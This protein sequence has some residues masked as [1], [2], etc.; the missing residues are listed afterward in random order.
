MCVA[1]AHLMFFLI[2]V[3]DAFRR[4]FG[5]NGNSPRHSKGSLYPPESVSWTFFKNMH[6]L[7]YKRINTF[8]VPNTSGRGDTLSS[9]VREKGADWDFCVGGIMRI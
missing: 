6:F 7:T 3:P 1:Q 4:I 9:T 5:E 2:F 8:C